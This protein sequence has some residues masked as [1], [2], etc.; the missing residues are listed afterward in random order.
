MFDVFSKGRSSFNSTKVIESVHALVPPKGPI[1]D[2]M[3]CMVEDLSRFGEIRRKPGAYSLPDGT[4]IVHPQ[5]YSAFRSRL[6]RSISA[7]NERMMMDAMFGRNALRDAR[8]GE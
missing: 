5:V 1:S 6:S 3:R 7:L 2:D 4:M 8:G